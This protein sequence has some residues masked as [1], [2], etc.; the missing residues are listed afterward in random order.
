MGEVAG[1]PDDDAD[2]EGVRGGDIGRLVQ[3]RA[4]DGLD[5]G[6][7]R[8]DDGRVQDA[9]EDAEHD[10]DQH[11]PARATALDRRALSA[12]CRPGG[13]RGLSGRGN[14][15]CHSGFFLLTLYAV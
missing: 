13:A 2:G 7:G 6:D 10:G 11:P 15:L 8:V 4:E 9:D 14:C 1:G 3:S 12:R 5:L